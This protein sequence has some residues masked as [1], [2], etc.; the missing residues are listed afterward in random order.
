MRSLWLA[1]LLAAAAASHAQSFVKAQYI[2]FRTNDAKKEY[3]SPLQLVVTDQSE[4]GK[5]THYLPGLGLPKSG[6]PPA[7]W[8][9][10][11]MVRLIR[12]KGPGMQI[13]F[14]SDGKFYS[15]VGKQG[16]FPAS[17]G[18]RDFLLGVEKRAKP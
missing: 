8:R 1:A 15:V 4:I 16:D 18:F 9:A 2:F 7:G 3:P 6:L 5:L 11:G 10:W 17:K 12:A 13:F 14:P